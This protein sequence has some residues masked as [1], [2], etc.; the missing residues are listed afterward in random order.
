M[1]FVALLEESFARDEPQRGD[2]ITGTV[3]TVDNY[4]LIVDVGLGRDGIVERR[5]LDRIHEDVNYQDGRS[6][7]CH[8]DSPGRRR[9]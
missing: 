6:T 5:D 1:D 7:G 4:G 2:I 8:G 3:L 9:R